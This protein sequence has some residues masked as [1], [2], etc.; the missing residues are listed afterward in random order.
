MPLDTTPNM[1]NTTMWKNDTTGCE[2]EDWPTAV[3][4]F[5]AIYY[6]IICL[7][8]VI[9]NVVNLIALP[10]A[11]AELG[12]NTVLL[13]RALAVV[14][15]LAGII[16]VGG[17]F[18]H[19][20]VNPC[21]MEPLIMYN[22]VRKLLNV[23][24]LNYSILILG[25]VSVHRYL[26]IKR[27]LTH[28]A[29]L[30]HRKTMYMLVFVIVVGALHAILGYLLSH[31]LIVHEPGDDCYFQAQYCPGTPKEFVIVYL[32]IFVCVTVVITVTNLELVPIIR[33][34]R[35]EISKQSASDDIELRISPKS[36]AKRQQERRPRGVVTLILVILTFYICCAPAIVYD[37]Y[38]IITRGKNHN[39]VVDHLFTAL[40]MTNTCMNSF[41]YL[42]T[43]R[44][45]RR[46][47]K[48]T[49]TGNCFISKLCE[50]LRSCRGIS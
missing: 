34:H 2:V 31:F 8:A 35:K 7:V 15:L 41:V 24:L 32:F 28:K 14:D 20:V 37:S 43:M 5:M 21:T 44:S 47:V 29:L 48:R 25:C 18:V 4:I 33:N 27:P 45:F 39:E 42:L 38:V 40:L 49:V 16:G 50:K 36:I 10:H 26:V 1:T 17:K 23:T 3:S 9:S 13:F 12:A 19:D 11:K 6:G 22:T 30:T 46:V